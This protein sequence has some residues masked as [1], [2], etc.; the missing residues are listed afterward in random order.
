M[1]ALGLW[2]IL[3]PLLNFTTNIF[4]NKFLLISSFLE[5]F[6]DVFAI[7]N[8]PIGSLLH[9]SNSL[10]FKFACEILFD[11]VFKHKNLILLLNWIRVQDFRS[12]NLNLFSLNS[13]FI[14]SFHPLFVKEW[15]PHLWV[16]KIPR[17]QR[18][19]FI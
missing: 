19:N 9:L 4:N 17:H 2:W 7:C 10:I 11:L 14:M 18:W 16:V 1:S 5:H 12:A 6:S 13:S 15:R 8:I 3:Q